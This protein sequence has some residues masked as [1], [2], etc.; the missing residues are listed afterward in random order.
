MKVGKS[1]PCIEC[2]RVH[3]FSS[4]DFVSYRFDEKK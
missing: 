1:Y 3:E 4:F 2:L